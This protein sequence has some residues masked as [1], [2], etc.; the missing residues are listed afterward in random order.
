MRRRNA[1]SF[2]VHGF[3]CKFSASGGCPPAPHSTE[4]DPESAKGARKPSPDFGQL[5]A[6]GGS[7]KGRRPPLR[8]RAPP[9]ARR[10]ARRAPAATAAV[11]TRTGARAGGGSG[12]GRRTRARRRRG[13]V[14]LPHA[15][16]PELEVDVAHAEGGV[17]LARGREERRRSARGPRPS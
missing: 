11:A 10:P 1:G 15:H 16:A 8:A 14:P 6:L 13:R 17:P 12:G 7:P 4:R 2:R 9:R 3:G 5:E